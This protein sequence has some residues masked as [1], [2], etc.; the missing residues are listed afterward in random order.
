M[1]LSVG[2][3]YTKRKLGFLA[4]SLLKR[5]NSIGI[6]S[7]DMQKPDETARQNEELW[8]SRAETY[9]TRF[10]FTRWT[11]RK[12]VS[13]LQLGDNPHLLDLACGTGWALRYAANRTNEHGEYYGV[14]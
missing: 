8:D 5:S 6:T 1:E 10:R 2:V 3:G 14:D 7:R 13:L 12:L 4:E 11:Q 9:D